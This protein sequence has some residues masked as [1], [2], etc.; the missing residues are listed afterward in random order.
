MKKHRIIK[1]LLRKILKLFLTSYV[2]SLQDHSIPFMAIDDLDQDGSMSDW[3]NSSVIIK[4]HS[5]KSVMVNGGDMIETPVDIVL[6]DNLKWARCFFDF[7]FIY[8][9]F[10]F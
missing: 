1:Y 7:F 6:F 3:N 8:D 5:L 9:V 10:N 4:M 2:R